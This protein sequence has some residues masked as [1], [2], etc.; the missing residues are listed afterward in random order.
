[1]FKAPDLLESL[2]LSISPKMQPSLLQPLEPIA[3][4]IVAPLW[5][6]LQALLLQNPPIWLRS[7]IVEGK[8]GTNPKLLE[9]CR[10]SN[11]HV[12]AL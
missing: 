3:T 8:L 11:P 6:L 5:S 4:F 9:N 1:M 12:R 2:T 7:W 10:M